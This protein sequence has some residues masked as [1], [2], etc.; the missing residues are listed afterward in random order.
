MPSAAAAA[1]AAAAGA[2]TAAA[3]TCYVVSETDPHSTQVPC[4]KQAVTVVVMSMRLVR[5]MRVML[6][7]ANSVAAYSHPHC[8]LF[9]ALRDSSTHALVFL[10]CRVSLT[11]VNASDNPFYRMCHRR[12]RAAAYAL[13]RI[14]DDCVRTASSGDMARF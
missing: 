8:Y 14:W 4:S 11:V 10:T 1:A 9:S 5:M 3:A 7:V 6:N 13:L 2:A 12:F